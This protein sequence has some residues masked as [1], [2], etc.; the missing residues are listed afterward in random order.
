MVFYPPSWVPKLP[1][2][3]PDSIPISDFIFNEKYG[4]YPLARSRPFFTCGITGQSY[5]AQ[6]VKERVEYLARGLAEELGWRPNHKTEWDK[7]VGVFSANTVGVI[8]PHLVCELIR[9]AAGHA[10]FSL[11]DA[12]TWWH[13][14]PCKCPV[15]RL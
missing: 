9:L 11:G 13:P 10:T 7:V 12:S 14:E 4:R 1:F 6:Q 3:L 8:H 2:D 5:S 15:F